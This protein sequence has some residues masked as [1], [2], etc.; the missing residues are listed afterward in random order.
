MFLDKN[1]YI[2]DTL[3]TYGVEFNNPDILDTFIKIIK[4][5]PEK[6]REEFLRIFDEQTCIVIFE[7]DLHSHVAIIDLEAGDILSINLYQFA[8]DLANNNNSGEE[9]TIGAIKLLHSLL[10]HERIQ[11]LKKEERIKVDH[12]KNAITVDGVTWIYHDKIKPYLPLDDI[13]GYIHD[14]IMGCGAIQL[15]DKDGDVEAARKGFIE[16]AIKETK[17]NFKD[18]QILH[19]EKL[20]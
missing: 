18:E 17:Q 19:Q 11:I 16:K 9:K 3:F 4:S 1:F 15:K 8:E 12:D 5:F 10:Y 7:R 13:Y 14:R 6:I 20:Q 2:K